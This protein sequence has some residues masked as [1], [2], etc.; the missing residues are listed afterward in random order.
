MDATTKEIPIGLVTVGRTTYEVFRLAVGENARRAGILANYGLR[1][2]R[3]AMYF[4]T[5]HGPK[6]RLNV[7]AL[8][9]ATPWQPSPS[10]IGNLRH[11][12]R[13]DLAPFAEVC[14]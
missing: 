2:P 14:R 3:G 10:A 7:S 4:V 6:Y 12:T 11:L 5:D 8:G 13:E 1:G 9:G